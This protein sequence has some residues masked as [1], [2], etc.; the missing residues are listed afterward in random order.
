MSSIWRRFLISLSASLALAGAAAA[1]DCDALIASFKSA[2]EDKGFERLKD[3]MAAIADDSA[4]NFD[5]DTYRI[6][7]INSIIDMAGAASTDD[8]RKQMIEFVEGIMEIGGNWR[9]AEHLGDYHAGRGE[10]SE[11]LGAY[12]TAISLLSRAAPPATQQDREELL[13]RAEAAKSQAS[14]DQ[15]GKTSSRFAASKRDLSGRF[16]GIYS[17]ELLRGF[18]VLAVP[19]PI[20]FYFGQARFTPAGEKAIEELAEVV[21]QQ[22]VETVTL[23]GHTDPRGDH[24]YNIELSKR[25]AAAARD[26]LLSHGVKARILV[27]GKGPDEPFDVSLLGRTVSQSEAWALDRRVEWVRKGEPD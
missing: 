4:C 15:E 26:Y 22:N 12:E 25:R 3:A 16:T 27:D 19:L 13:A 9:S 6:Q 2:I 10:Y 8:A 7:E 18:E 11:A 1:A 14:D 20:N 23:V 24:G 21:K 5:I 17:R